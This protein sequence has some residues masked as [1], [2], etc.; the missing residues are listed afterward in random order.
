MLAQLHAAR[1]STSR[2]ADEVFSDERT[3]VNL[4]VQADD[5][6]EARVRI[7][8]ALFPLVGPAD[9][10]PVAAVRRTDDC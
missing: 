1:I 8:R 9:F 7:M 6:R 2:E 5:E 10:G 3:S 4:E